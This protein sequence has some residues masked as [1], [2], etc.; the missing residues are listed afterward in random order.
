MWSSAD[1]LEWTCHIQDGAAPWPARS[2][3]D[4][5]VWDGKLWVLGGHR[6]IADQP[7]EVGTDGNR[8]DVWY[9]DDGEHWE[10]LSNTPWS[11]RHAC[12][13]HVHGDALFLAAGSAVTISPEQVELSQQDFTHRTES[14]WCPGDVWRLDRVDAA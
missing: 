9:S 3:H 14:A 12:A 6:G 4:T 10:Q 8:N 2:Y 5:A 7:S 1:G 11:L 13:V